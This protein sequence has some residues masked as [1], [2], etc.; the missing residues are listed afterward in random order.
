M[1]KPLLAIGQLATSL[2]KQSEP[3]LNLMEQLGYLP[4]HTA[5]HLKRADVITQLAQ[6]GQS[7]DAMNDHLL[8]PLMIACHLSNR[9]IAT[10]LMTQLGADPNIVDRNG[11][12]CLYYACGLAHLEK[13]G[14]RAEALKEAF[15]NIDLIQCLLEQGANP[16][17]QDRR[18]ETLLHH[19]GQSTLNLSNILRQKPHHSTLK[20]S[21]HT[22]M[23]FITQKTVAQVM[24]L[25]EHRADIS[26]R[27]NVGHT[28]LHKAAIGGNPQIINA[29]LSAGGD[30]FLLDQDNNGQT[31]HDLAT[32]HKQSAAAEALNNAIKKKLPITDIK[33]LHIPKATG[34]FTRPPVSQESI[35]QSESLYAL[36]CSQRR[37]FMTEWARVIAAF[38]L[39]LHWKDIAKSAQACLP[40]LLN[41]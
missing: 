27:D 34:Y 4:I 8:T 25:L 21:H 15:D 3:L 22:L 38:E 40:Q 32:Q 39:G 11:F 19:L 28:A 24:L 10:Q 5:V 18:G 29:I 26:V 23:N 7:S 30:I 41:K 1:M 37:H 17:Q 35:K 33:D 2:E 9:P 14:Y 6:L 16:N 12:N 20:E 31:P 36:Q 13:P